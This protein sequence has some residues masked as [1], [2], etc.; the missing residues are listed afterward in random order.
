MK[1]VKDLVIEIV[2]GK[3]NSNDGTLILHAGFASLLFKFMFSA[4]MLGQKGEHYPVLS[5]HMG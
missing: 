5:F 1:L 4:L 2:A 3:A